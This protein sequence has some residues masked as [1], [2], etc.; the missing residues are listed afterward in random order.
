[1]IE[2]INITKKFG[3]FT[4]VNNLNLIL[5]PGK[6]TAFL[7]PNGAGKTTTLKMLVGLMKPTAG[8]VKINGFEF[9]SNQMELKKIMSYIPDFPFLYERLTGIEYLEF[10]AGINDVPKDLSQDS[11]NKNLELFHISNVKNNL[12]T[13]YSHGM[14]Q[15]L[16]FC[17]ALLKKPKILIIDEPMVG[18]DPKTTRIFKIVL[19]ELASAGTLVFLST[20]QLLVAEKLADNLIIIDNGSIVAQGT[21][22]QLLHNRHSDYNLEDFFLELTDKNSE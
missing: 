7:G 10:V 8:E 17:A 6:I 18:L 19:K 12:I 5:Q 9:Y 3:S 16:I 4:A 13:T 22:K 20:H 11:I 2:L 1:M 14:R 21:L 15:R